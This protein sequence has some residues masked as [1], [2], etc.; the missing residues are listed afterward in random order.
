MYTIKVHVKIE[1]HDNVED[2]L[3]LS[4]EVIPIV[5]QFKLPLFLSFSANL[6]LRPSNRLH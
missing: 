6:F 1:F 3:V 4:L 2:C 5:H